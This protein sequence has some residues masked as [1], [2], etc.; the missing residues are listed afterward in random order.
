[1]AD[2]AI[3]QVHGASQAGHGHGDDVHPT[4][5]QYW[6]VF[7]ILVVFTAI[8]IA[9]SYL[10]FHGVGLV[11]PLLVL[12]VM[13]FALVAGA[14]MHLYFDMKILNGRLFTMA[15]GG[16]IALAVAVFM[17]VFGAFRFHI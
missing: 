11:A 16:A 5:K 7:V 12:M 13:K 15:F 14:F 6:I 3:D 17:A 1:M 9:W 4:E 2:T 10:G 8:E